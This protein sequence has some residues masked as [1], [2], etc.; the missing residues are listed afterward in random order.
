MLSQSFK[1]FPENAGSRRKREN[2]V[3]VCALQPVT[4]HNV[5]W[6]TGVDCILFSMRT[7]CEALMYGSMFFFLFF[8]SKE[9]RSMPKM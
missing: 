9:D 2:T 1:L 5:H 7:R 4:L 3:L 8:F 6:H